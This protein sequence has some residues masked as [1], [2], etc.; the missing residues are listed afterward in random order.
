MSETQICRPDLDIFSCFRF[1]GSCSSVLVSA[2]A[3]LA[4]KNTTGGF[5]GRQRGW[6]RG[7]SLSCFDGSIEPLDPRKKLWD[8]EYCFSESRSLGSASL[9]P[10]LSQS[11]A[12]MAWPP[13][14]SQH[15]EECRCK[16]AVPSMSAGDGLSV[17][18]S[19]QVPRQAA[20]SL[21][22]R[23]HRVYGQQLLASWPPFDSCPR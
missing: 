7:C 15:V 11:N 4:L 19:I 2:S 13:P 3:Y 21:R 6:S 18:I 8:T 10:F 5:R 17:S 22:R 14:P 9:S 1:I 16:W 12:Q 23:T 20:S